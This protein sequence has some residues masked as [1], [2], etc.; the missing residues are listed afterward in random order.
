MH[1]MLTW[2]SCFKLISQQPRPF[3]SFFS[4]RISSHYYVKGNAGCIRGKAINLSIKVRFIRSVIAANINLNLI[5]GYL[6]TKVT[7]LLNSVTLM[8]LTYSECDR[9]NDGEGQKQSFDHSLLVIAIRIIFHIEQPNSKFNRNS[10]GQGL[11]EEA[12]LPKDL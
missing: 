8:S 5:F 9:R 11:Q 6:C 7:R 10:T 2:A 4:C 12:K 3:T 1:T